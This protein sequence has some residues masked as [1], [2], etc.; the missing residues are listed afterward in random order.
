MAQS[1]SVIILS[2]SHA[3]PR[4]PTSF[5]LT[6][7]YEDE[8]N[9]TITLEWNPPKGSGPEVI[10]HSYEI[11]IT[12]KPISYPSSNTIY[13]TSWNVTLNYNVQYEATIIA[14]NCEGESSPVI[15]SDI[16]FSELNYYLYFLI[17]IHIFILYSVNCGNPR[18]PTNGSLGNYSRTTKGAEVMFMCDLGFL[19]TSKIK[20]ICND[21][22]SWDPAPENHTCLCM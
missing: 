3:A 1:N 8:F 13:S 6:N 20:A 4:A 2:S 21:T 16:E 15:L 9:I 14:V 11:V 12:P 17:L 18:S 19:P 5:N 10:V 7:G 22:G